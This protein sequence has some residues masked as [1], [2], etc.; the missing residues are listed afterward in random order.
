MEAR[1]EK[2]ER[3]VEGLLLA[4][5]MSTRHAPLGMS[6]DRRIV[7]DRPRL[8]ALSRSHDL[9]T[10]CHGMQTAAEL[11]RAR[12]SV[13]EDGEA[14]ELLSVCSAACAQMLGTIEN[15]LTKLG[16]SQL[17]AADAGAGSTLAR[18]TVEPAAAPAQEEM[19][20]GVTTLELTSRLFQNMIATTNVVFH[21]G[22]FLEDGGMVLRYMSPNVQRVCGHTNMGHLDGQGNHLHPFFQV[23]HPAEVAFVKDAFAEARARQSAT[24]DPAALVR[25]SI[26]RRFRLPDQ[27]YIP[28]LSTGCVDSDH[29]YMMCHALTSQAHRE[30]AMRCRLGATIRE[31][32]EPA[33]SLLAAASLLMAR[34]SIESDSEAKFLL[35]AMHAAC[36]LLLGIVGNV[37]SLQII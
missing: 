37:A 26:Y 5:L 22:D 19:P 33:T 34:P 36:S 15:V 20:F 6:A 24:G 12:T 31:L 2:S 27:S 8:S 30:D 1:D 10:P 21:S 17:G 23:L 11:L 14:T 28:V 35:N 3:R 18:A 29:F 9:R 7:P 32:R 4:F 16:L 13:A 25:L